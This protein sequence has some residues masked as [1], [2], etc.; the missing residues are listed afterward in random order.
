[1]ASIEIN[2]GSNELDDAV[3]DRFKIPTLDCQIVLETARRPAARQILKEKHSQ[4]RLFAHLFLGIGSRRR[5][6]S[7][8][9][10]SLNHSAPDLL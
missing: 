7:A 10:P 1:V 4:R 5:G 6:N 8:I 3:E 9:G 2:M